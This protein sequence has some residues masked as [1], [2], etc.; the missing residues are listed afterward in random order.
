MAQE[1]R[2]QA[3]APENQQTGVNHTAPQ[4]SE[5]SP[6]ASA[7]DGPP[8][9]TALTG[10]V[11]AGAQSYDRAFFAQYNPNTA[12]DMLRRLPGVQQILDAASQA[13]QQRGLGSTGDQILIGGR[14]MA[15]KGQIVAALRRVPARNVQRIELIRGT[16][17]GSSVLSEG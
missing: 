14:R 7:G 1:A 4:P 11:D 10:E 6:T 12:E 15:A 2:A 5:A 13:G 17:S 3:P 9:A 8:R 16:S